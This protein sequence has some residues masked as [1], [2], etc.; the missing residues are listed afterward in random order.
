MF[1]AFVVLNRVPAPHTTTQISPRGT[2]Q[3]KIVNMNS[4]IKEAFA[5]FEERSCIT[6]ELDTSLITD[7]GIKIVEN[8]SKR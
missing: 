7:N 1:N 3:H 4:L 5:L 2:A 8:K 6:W